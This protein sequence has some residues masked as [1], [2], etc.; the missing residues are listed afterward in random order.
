MYSWDGSSS[1]VFMNH[2]MSPETR[3]TALPLSGAEATFSRKR[4]SPQSYLPIPALDL[5]LPRT[6][7]ISALLEQRSPPLGHG[8]SV[9]HDRVR[10]GQ[11][12]DSSPS[13][14]G[15]PWGQYDT[16]SSYLQ[17]PDQH[18]RLLNDP[19]G[20]NQLDGMQKIPE[21]QGGHSAVNEAVPHGV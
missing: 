11:H 1:M 9:A 6:S 19:G 17:H 10:A 21:Q 15:S 18:V 8:T 14:E 4:W 2:T 7:Q 20:S 16:A 5:L 13:K 3:E 12:G